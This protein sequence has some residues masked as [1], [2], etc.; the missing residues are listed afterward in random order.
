MNHF[1]EIF[2]DETEDVMSR[3][4]PMTR[5]KAEKVEA[6]A[7]INLNEDKFS[8]RIVSEESEEE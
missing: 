7:R 5:H 4:G 6:G 1:V 8:I 2:E 3:M